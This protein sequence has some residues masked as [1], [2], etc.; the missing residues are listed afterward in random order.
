M[1]GRGIL[2]RL[3]AVMATLLALSCLYVVESPAED[4]PNIALGKSVSAST[5]S[6]AGSPSQIVDGSTGSTWWSYQG[7][8][9]NEQ[10][11]VLDLGALYTI[12]KINIYIWQAWGV[13]VSTS[14]DGATFTEIYSGTSSG[15]YS[16]PS[17]YDYNGLLSLSG[18]APY[19][20]RYIKHYAYA[21]WNQYVGVSEIEVYERQPPVE[22]N[23]TY[24]AGESPK[25]F[26][27][28]WTFGA[29]GTLKRPDG[30]TED[31]S[32]KVQWSGSGTFTPATGSRSMPVFSAAGA[33]TIT[34]KVKVDGEEYT[35]TTT[36]QAV[37]P[38]GYAAL[39]D[40][41]FCPADAHGSPK[42]PLPV[43]GPIVS[44]SSTVAIN[45][46]PAAR[47][48][49][50]GVHAACSGPNVFEIIGGDSEVLIDGR[51]AARFGDPTRH[52]GGWGQ[53]ITPGRQAQSFSSPSGG[54]GGAGSISRRALDSAAGAGGLSGTVTTVAA[55]P[56]TGLA[57]WVFPKAGPDPLWAETDENGHFNITGIAPGKSRVLF[58]SRIRQGSPGAPVWVNGPYVAEWYDNALSFGETAEVTISAESTATADAQ[59]AAGGSFSGR[60][61]DGN[62]VGIPNVMV[63]VYGSAT[64]TLLW[65]WTDGS[66]DYTIMGLPADTYK[67]LAR[68][69]RLG[70][71]DSW[72]GGSAENASPIPVGDEEQ[73]AGINIM[74]SSGGSIKGKLNDMQDPAVGVAVQAVHT[75]TNLGGTAVTDDNGRYAIT[76]LPDG[77]YKVR[78]LGQAK[79]ALDIWYPNAPGWDEAAKVTV[80]AAA[81]LEGIDGQLWPIGLADIIKEL[82]LLAGTNVDI[83]TFVAA[84]NGD[85]KIGL[86]E[87]IYALQKL[88]WM[89]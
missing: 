20:A 69:S 76:G 1:E 34:L 3:F 87:V 56:I 50:V 24:P 38:A 61:I 18:D 36:V 16:N 4:G 25:V 35:K 21:N 51:P 62:G 37:S 45:G 9:R 32:D 66:G 57:V 84:R 8:G 71:A 22:L 11:F 17:D 52:C 88:A 82:Q 12:D 85:G 26:T 7:G 49:D 86:A 39:S 28:G 47:S 27:A 63:T 64:K 31:I 15:S 14:T 44:G 10:G 67:L 29:K 77:T 54:L 13:A 70:F 19:K 5:N 55:D 74:L 43:V 60:I 72:Y 79:G 42:D 89:R 41:A 83:G 80:S 23:L 65:H 2:A 48:G 30:G 6:V 73:I 59:L 33:N 68:G 58:S 40:K 53:I 46:R 78:F 81:N 75:E